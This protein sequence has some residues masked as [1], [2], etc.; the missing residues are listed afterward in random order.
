M[1]SSGLGDGNGFRDVFPRG[2]YF[3]AFDRGVIFRFY[4]HV[5]TDL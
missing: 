2:K 5:G 1:A 3:P 4:R